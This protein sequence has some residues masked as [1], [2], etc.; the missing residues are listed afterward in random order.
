MEYQRA[1]EKIFRH[2]S[3][4]NIWNDFIPAEA[5]IENYFD[6]MTSSTIRERWAKY[7][8]WMY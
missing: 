3:A 8:Q 4:D 1:L 2:T 5:I 7:N 6:Y